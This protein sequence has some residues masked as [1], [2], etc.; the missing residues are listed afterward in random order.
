MYPLLEKEGF[1]F[2]NFIL[3]TLLKF[4]LSHFVV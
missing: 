4:K 2:A 3:N 1:H